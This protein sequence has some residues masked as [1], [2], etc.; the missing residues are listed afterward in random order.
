MDDR[1][2]EI[3]HFMSHVPFNFPLVEVLLKQTLKTAWD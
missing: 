3:G 1:Y 2:R